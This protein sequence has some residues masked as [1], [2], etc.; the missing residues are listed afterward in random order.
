LRRG[1]RQALLLLGLTLLAGS[2]ATA[3]ESPAP[4]P[5]Q[6]PAPEKSEKRTITLGASFDLFRPFSS[7][8]RD[9]FG[10]TWIGIGGGFFDRRQPTHWAFSFDL[11]FRGHDDI[12]EATLIP[13]TF[14]AVRGLGAKTKAGWQPF[15]ALRVGPYYGKVEGDRL[16]TEDETL[17]LNANAALGIIYRERYALSLRYDF[18]SHF[19]GTDFSGLSLRASVRVLQVKL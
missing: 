9:R 4:Q 12:G 6:A 15:V 2:R 5:P 13:L 10:D 1:G 7:T 16:P 11:D 17:G 14:G 3:A 8:T 18:F 19:A